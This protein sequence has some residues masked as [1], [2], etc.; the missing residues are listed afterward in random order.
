[1]ALFFSCVRENAPGRSCHNPDGVA[2]GTRLQFPE[3]GSPP[4]KI[5]AFGRS[6]VTLVD[7]D[8]PDASLL[9]NK[10]T[11][12]V[13]HAGGERVKPG[14]EDE[15]VLKAWIQRLTRPSAHDLPL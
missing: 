13:P 1:F 15:V 12:R 8:H 5:E 6:L 3:P 9:L 11:L 2:S 4:E 7:R 10:P 14:S